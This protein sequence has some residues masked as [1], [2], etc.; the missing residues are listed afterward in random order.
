MIEIALLVMVTAVITHVATMA[1]VDES[2]KECRSDVQQMGMPNAF[3][4]DN[5]ETFTF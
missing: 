1:A 3:H 4:Q 2:R 5:N